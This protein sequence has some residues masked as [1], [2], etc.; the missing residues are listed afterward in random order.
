MKL[1]YE[2]FLQWNTKFFV[3]KVLGLLHFG[4]CENCMSS[5]D[6]VTETYQKLGM[7]ELWALGNDVLVNML[8]SSS[9]FTEVHEVYI[10]TLEKDFIF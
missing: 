8:L 6:L 5:A 4:S 2:I 3:Q 7:K 9:H 10:G 1:K